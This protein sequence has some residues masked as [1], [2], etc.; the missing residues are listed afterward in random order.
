MDVPPG[1]SQDL[2][3][4]GRRKETRLKLALNTPLKLRRVQVKPKTSMGTQE[5]D[6]DDAKGTDNQKRRPT[7][8]YTTKTC[9]SSSA[10][11]PRVPPAP[12]LTHLQIAAWGGEDLFQDTLT[13][14]QDTAFGYRQLIGR[15][16]VVSEKC[17]GSTAQL[18]AAPGGGIR[19]IR[20]GKR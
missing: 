14:L 4:L 2:P 3:E 17:P 18:R 16:T 1:S 19:P 10:G 20:S 6:K 9:C 11:L 7:K 12:G 15:Q 5:E 8:S 13:P